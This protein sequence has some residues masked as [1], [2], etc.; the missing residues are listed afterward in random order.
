MAKWRNEDWRLLQTFS[1]VK[2]EEWRP[3]KNVKI[4]CEDCILK[5]EDRKTN[6]GW[7]D[8]HYDSHIM[9]DIVR[10]FFKQAIQNEN[11]YFKVHCTLVNSDPVDLQFLLIR[12]LN[13]VSAQPIRLYHVFQ[14]THSVL[15]WG[16][17]HWRREIYLM[18]TSNWFFKK[19]INILK[20]W[21]FKS[22]KNPFYSIYNSQSD[23]CIK[24]YK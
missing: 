18:S 16:L 5:C 4:K 21:I 12:H 10:I 17:W 13:M 3:A 2:T 1:H 22:I 6:F 14:I 8:P 19:K 9:N 23:V 11:I 20:R 7:S 24:N 15:T